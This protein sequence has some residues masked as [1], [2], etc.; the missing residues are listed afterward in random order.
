M[1]DIGIPNHNN[2]MLDS[3]YKNRNSYFFIQQKLPAYYFFMYQKSKLEA[4]LICTS[5][6]IMKTLASL[7]SFVKILF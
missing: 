7:Q 6:R 5:F 1:N 2:L 3:K 4:E